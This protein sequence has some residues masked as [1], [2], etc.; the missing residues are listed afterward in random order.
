VVE[1]CVAGAGGGVA[2]S[3]PRMLPNFTQFLTLTE[4]CVN[5]SNDTGSTWTGFMRLKTACITALVK[6]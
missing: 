4:F 3:N 1:L 6:R 5:V 2:S